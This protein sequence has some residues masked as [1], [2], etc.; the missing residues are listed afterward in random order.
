V[1]DNLSDS[2][3]IE[4]ANDDS[5]TERTDADTAGKTTMMMIRGKLMLT[6]QHTPIILTVTTTFGHCQRKEGRKE[7][8]EPAKLMKS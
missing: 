2:G 6:L 8:A 5:C 3:K 7:G 1:F 4:S